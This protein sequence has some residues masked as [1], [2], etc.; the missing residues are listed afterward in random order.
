MLRHQFALFEQEIV[1]P[2]LKNIAA[3]GYEL[4]VGGT[5]A[6]SC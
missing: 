5:L 3:A 1:L 4:M 6:I 2:D